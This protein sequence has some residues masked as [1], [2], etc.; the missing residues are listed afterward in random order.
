MNEIFRKA[1]E[2]Q[3]EANKDV[4]STADPNLHVLAYAEMLADD[5]SKHDTSNCFHHS[6]IRLSESGYDPRY[7]L[8]KALG[9][10]V[11]RI[12][13]VERNRFLKGKMYEDAYL[14]AME[15]ADV[16]ADANGYFRNVLANIKVFDD[17]NI[18]GHMD[19]VVRSKSGKRRILEIKKVTPSGMEASPF[20]RHIYQLQAYLLAWQLQEWNMVGDYDLPGELHYVDETG[21]FDPPV[22]KYDVLSNKKIQNEI[23]W[24]LEKLIKAIQTG[25]IPADSYWGIDFSNYY[26]P[27][28]F[29]NWLK[30]ER[31]FVSLQEESEQ[32]FDADEYEKLCS[33]LRSKNY[34]NV[35]T[36]ANELVEATATGAAAQWYAAKN[37]K[38]TKEE[39]RLAKH[40][41]GFF[42]A[43]ETYIALPDGAY[44]Q[45]TK[46]AKR[47]TLNV[48][49]YQLA[50]HSMPDNAESFVKSEGG[51]WTKRIK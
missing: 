39:K 42:E 18:I 47:K 2:A 1:C 23:R 38:N 37:A 6:K 13:D 48:D 7:R 11:E 8:A 35:Q 41:E 36:D 10:Y 32:V 40:L 51:T 12:T 34:E 14:T 4:T 16:T 50:G 27:P 3:Y 44:L 46:S 15:K 21:S 22:I 17:C 24:T 31:Q 5:H 20:P 19:C 43:G 29:L 45:A 28:G 25:G 26:A 49:D 33:L 9:L 30:S